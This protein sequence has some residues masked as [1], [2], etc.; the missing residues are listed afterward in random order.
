MS[1]VFFSE[2]SY[3]NTLV[4]ANTKHEWLPIAWTFDEFVGS[5]RDWVTWIFLIDYSSKENPG[6]PNEMLSNIQFVGLEEV[7]KPRFVPRENWTNFSGS[8]S[9]IQQFKNLVRKVQESGPNTV[10]ID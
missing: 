9:L 2:I 3:A 6:I 1:L 5:I 8:G 7:P 4:R 10:L